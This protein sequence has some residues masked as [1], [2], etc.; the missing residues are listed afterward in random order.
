[1]L[2]TQNYHRD[3]MGWKYAISLR[4]WRYTTEVGG[5]EMSVVLVQPLDYKVLEQ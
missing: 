4:Q 1:M 3:D 5:E 2:H